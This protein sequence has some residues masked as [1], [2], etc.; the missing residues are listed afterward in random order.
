MDATLSLFGFPST[1]AHLELV[2]RTRSWRLA[3]A[4]GF[5][6][7]GAVMAPVLGLIPPHAPW[8]LMALTV[9]G[10]LGLRKWK[11]R[12]TILS[13]SARCPKCSGKLSISRKTPLRKTMTIPCPG[14]HHDSRL[15][16]DPKGP[17]LSEPAAQ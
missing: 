5:V 16:V 7:G 4:T 14:C 3:R 6:G 9:G 10:I 12:Y 13:L 17:S 2:E 1:P 8:A 11:E 15:L